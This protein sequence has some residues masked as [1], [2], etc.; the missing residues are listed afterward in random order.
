MLDIHVIIVKEHYNRTKSEDFLVESVQ[1]VK[2]R[3]VNVESRTKIFYG[4]KCSNPFYK[5]ETRRGLQ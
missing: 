1:R 3:K 4:N 2:D 5:S